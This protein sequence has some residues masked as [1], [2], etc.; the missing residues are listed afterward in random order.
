MNLKAFKSLN[1]KTVN[2][3]INLETIC[4]KHDN[5]YG[6][7]F[8]DTSLNFNHNIKSVFLLYEAEELISI[9]SMFI[10]TQ[11]EAEISALTEPKHRRKGYFNALLARAIQEL[12]KFDVPDI[13]FVCE[14]QSI[15]GNLVIA[16]LNVKY[17][18]SDYLMRFNE[19]RYAPSRDACRLLLSKPDLGDFEKIIDTS[20]RI[21]D[22]SYD[23]AKDRIYYCYES[24]FREQY[25]AVLNDEIIGLC[26]INFESDEVAIFALGIVPEYRGQGYGTELLYL[27]VDS[28]WGRG[29]TKLTLE[30]NS[31][32]TRAFEL[33]KKFGFQIV[34]AF[35]YYRKKGC[36]TMK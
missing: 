34:T 14:S 24:A 31:E 12:K 9:L 26:T 28:L 20:M 30:V 11:Q 16:T 21:F 1:D 35:E 17:E 2:D 23:E 22:D 4:K 3:V 27:I 18:Y 25:M 19:D 33:Y 5:L 15:S 13:L 6:S 29:R 32:N 7:I 10:P 8:L 36:R